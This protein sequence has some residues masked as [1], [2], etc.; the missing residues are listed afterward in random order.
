MERRCER[1]RM[2]RRVMITLGAVCG[3][4]VVVVVSAYLAIP[5][6]LLQDEVYDNVPNR[7]SCS[8]VPTAAVVDKAV[9]EFPAIGEAY[10][11]AAE[12]CEGAI[13]EIQVADHATREEVED[14]LEETGNYDASTGW[15]WHSV[16]VAIRNV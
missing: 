6:L 15:W 1:P 4:V 13:L 7:V 2:S 16:P 14:F 10:P 12:R 5:T 9:E 11:F 8:G 3:S